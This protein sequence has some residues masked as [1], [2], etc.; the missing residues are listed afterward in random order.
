MTYLNPDQPAGVPQTP[1]TIVGLGPMGQAL[2]GA[3][4]RN[5]HPTTVWNRTASKADALAAQGAI[6]AADIASAVSASPLVIVCVLDY[7]AVHA[8]LEPAAEPLQSR[9]LVN[10]TADTPDR[11]RRTAEWAASHGIAYLDGA[12]MTPT[13]T[14]G[15][16]AASVLYSGP[17]DVYEG[18]LPALASIGGSA[19]YLGSDPGRVAAHDVA[20]LDLF[21]TTMSGYVHALALARTE[22]IA[23]RDFAVH[24]QGIARILPP[25]IDAFAAQADA[26]EYPGD[27]SNLRSAAAGMEHILHASSRHGLDVGVLSAARAIARRAIDAG[28]AEDSFA[29][30]ADVIGKPSASAP[31]PTTL[32]QP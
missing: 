26:G 12:I 27:A 23:A 21:W 22:G 5:G 6:R 4:L 9:T 17:A 18:V 29:R 32:K 28:Y 14:I 10:L 11:A 16:P 30:L 13:P 19:S 8:I 7:D 25:I 15:T 1:V 20:L 24:A 3:F 31:L 2:A